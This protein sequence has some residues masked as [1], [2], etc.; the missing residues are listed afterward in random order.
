MR[1]AKLSRRGLL[2]A[3]AATL[4]GACIPEGR[5]KLPLNMQPRDIG[6]GWKL[7]TPESVGLDPARARAVYEKVFSDDD[8]I[9]ALSLL[10]IKDGILV[11]EGYVRELG[12]I[13]RKT[14]IQSVTKSLTSLAFG[15]ARSRGFFPDV[16][17][18]LASFLTVTDPAKQSIT[19]EHLLTM[20]SGI[21]VDNETFGIELEMAERHHWTEWLLDQPLHSKPGE[22]F[23]YRDCDPQLVASAIL[24]ETGES[25]EQ[26]LRSTV[27]DSLGITDVHWFHSPDDEPA[28]AHGVWMRPRDLA[29]IG[30]LTRLG[31][32]FE[33]KSLVPESWISEATRAQSGVDPDDPYTVGFFYGYYFWIVPEIAAYSSWGH[34][35]TFG[36]VVPDQQLVMVL[37]SM[38]DAGHQIGSELDDIVDLAKILVG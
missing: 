19:L 36:L 11:A 7:G 4:A 22:R 10:V 25:V 13:T 14:H 32:T 33:G 35:G 26:I 12:D 8:F 30:E 28:G 15:V 6:D 34:G 16:H 23:N 17:A 3:G 38:P 31:G 5:L 24:A 9:N 20:R 2:G 29:K 1:R 37:T 18:P 21:D 27:F